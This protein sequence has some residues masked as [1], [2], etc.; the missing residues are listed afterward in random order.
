MIYKRR[1]NSS[2]TRGSFIKKLHPNRINKTYEFNSNGLE[3]FGVKYYRDT[4]ALRI[5]YLFS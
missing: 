4:K 5:K 3:V 1:F 2:E